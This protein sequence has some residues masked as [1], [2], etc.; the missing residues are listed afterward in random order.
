VVTSCW[1]EP[2]LAGNTHSYTGSP[3]E[4][5]LTVALTREYNSFN[6]NFVPTCN[7]FSSGGGT[8]HF[9]W[10]QLNGGFT[11]GN[12]HNPWG[13]IRWAL[14]QG[15]EDTRYFMN[16]EAITIESGYRCPHGNAPLPGSSP[17]SNHMEGI[18]AD[19]HVAGWNQTRWGQLT[20]AAT[21]A[22][23]TEIEP[24]AWDPSHA[25]AAWE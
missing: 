21:L 1:N 12:P 24:Y 16:D 25:H 20:T 6:V 3:P 14:T 18:A 2:F 23:A 9:S 10:P 13:I 8:A 19:M 5:Q 4:F 7:D 15:L 17:Q 22:G 11:N